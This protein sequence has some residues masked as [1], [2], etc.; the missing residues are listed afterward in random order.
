MS[1]KCRITVVFAS[2]ERERE[3]E[4]E[5]ARLHVLRVAFIHSLVQPIFI[6]HQLRPRHC[7]KGREYR[8]GRDVYGPCCHATDFLEGQDKGIIT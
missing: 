7:V 5:T 6:E 3:R 8:D 2:M 4:R 1:Q